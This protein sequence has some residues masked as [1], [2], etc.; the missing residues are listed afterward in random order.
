MEN[1]DQ[2]DNYE[3]DLLDLISSDL[4][5]TNQ[6]LI[7]EGSNEEIYAINISKVIEVLVYKNLDMVKNGSGENII[8]ATAKIREE[9]ATI[10]CFDEWFGNKT[11]DEKDYEFCILA[12]F[13]GHN[14]AIMVKNVEYIVNINFDEMKDNSI[15]NS[16]TNFVAKIKLNGKD[17]LCTIFDCDKLL[18]DI[19]SETYKIEETPNIV[20]KNIDSQKYVLFADDSRFIRKMVESIFEKLNLKSKIFEN[21]KE[22][23]DE[24]KTLDPNDVGLIITDLEMPV[25]DGRALIKSINEIPIYGDIN[26]IVHTNMSNF[27]IEK[28]LL[29]L[30]VKEVIGKINMEKLTIGINKYFKK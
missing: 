2:L 13:G 29:E 8:R 23:L 15:N 11:L 25:M 14:L 19:F 30:G 7:F 20:N 27:V 17:R 21:G 4:N 16:K 3:L 22:L 12:G 10:I 9:I 18:L 1:I 5:T 26:I 6:Y 24:L 28:S